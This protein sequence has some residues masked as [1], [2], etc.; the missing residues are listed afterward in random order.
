MKKFEPDLDPDPVTLG[1]VRSGSIRLQRTSLARSLSLRGR[2]REAR[3]NTPAN[4]YSNFYV[5]EKLSSIDYFLAS[6]FFR[7]VVSLSE[8]KEEKLQFQSLLETP[9]RL[10]SW[11][12]FDQ[13]KPALQLMVFGGMDWA[14]MIKTDA[15]IDWGKASHVY[16][17]IVSCE[18]VDLQIKATLQLARLAKH[19]PETILAS[20]VPFLVDLLSSTPRMQEAAAYALHCVACQHDGRLCPM[21]GQLGAIPLL[22]EL[23]RTSKEGFQKTLL[24]CLRTLVTFDGPNRVILAV[25]DGFEITLDLLSRCTDDRRRRY[26]LEI[27]SAL[28]MVREVRRALEAFSAL[29]FLV[30]ALSC[31]KMISRSRAAQTIGVL[32]ISRRR[33]HTLV[34]LGV[35]PALIEF[36]KEGDSSD[37]LVAANA[38]G[39]ISSHVDF[40]RLV[41]RSGAIPLYVE[42]LKGP[43]PRGKDIAEDAFCLLAVEEEN[44]VMISEQMVRILVG[45]SAEAIAAALDII[46]D[47]AGYKHSINVVRESGAIPVIVGLLQ[48]MNDDIREKAF[49]AIAQLSYDAANREAMVE[50][51]AI[52]IL[53]DNLTSDWEE[54][55][56]YASE[57][58]LNFTEDSVFREEVSEVHAIPSFL[59][60]QERLIRLR[61]SD[62]HMLRSMSMMEAVQLADEAAQL[63]DD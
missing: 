50:V 52:P 56:E 2:R 6:E 9:I 46:W 17:N 12:L 31:G 39:I 57:C 43:E 20:I 36:F 26:L 63:D 51:G 38:L 11:C 22:A 21:I 35:I 32:G 49:G 45:D 34:D 42:L 3:R 16:M 33:K 60:I 44:A 30:E 58:L 29:G 62:E 48:H 14:E 28:A 23:L 10:E 4:F 19:A 55:R 13:K 5:E 59:F 27:L 37:K 7:V 40:L 47:L 15:G 18:S 25:S 1:R 54:V 8:E 41:V 61:A 53:I 24:R